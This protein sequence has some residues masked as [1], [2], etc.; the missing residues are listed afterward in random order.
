MSTLQK[1]NC[2]STIIILSYGSVLVGYLTMAVDFQ[3]NLYSYHQ[4]ALVL[5]SVNAQNNH[6]VLGYSL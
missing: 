6:T 1:V 2:H 4:D 5:Q 3:E